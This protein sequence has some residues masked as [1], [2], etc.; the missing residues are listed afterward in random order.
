MPKM[1]LIWV[2]LMNN[3]HPTKT[4]C[5][6]HKIEAVEDHFTETDSEFIDFNKINTQLMKIYEMAQINSFEVVQGNIIKTEN[7]QVCTDAGISFELGTAR[8]LQQRGIKGNFVLQIQWIHGELLV[9][10][11]GTSAGLMFP[12]DEIDVLVE[13]YK[14]NSIQFAQDSRLILVRDKVLILK[15]GK[16]I[17]CVAGGLILGLDL[18]YRSLL[19]KIE[20]N[21]RNLFEMNELILNIIHSKLH[22]CCLPEKCVD[23]I[24]TKK[25]IH[26]FLKWAKNDA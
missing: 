8:H 17:H 14:L 24:W 19:K 16:E 12:R 15:P 3:H 26:C 5:V 10:S 2:L 25:T 6:L 18:D 9:Y 7:E 11:N 20:F 1:L 21:L 23:I 4:K 13:N 22:G